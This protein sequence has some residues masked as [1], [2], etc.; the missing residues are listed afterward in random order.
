MAN[1]PGPCAGLSFFR[2]QKLAFFSLPE[3]MPF[4]WLVQLSLLRVV[5]PIRGFVAFHGA[6]GLGSLAGLLTFS[7]LRADLQDPVTESVVW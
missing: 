6:L 7:V 1:G 3:L 5:G 2:D 4:P